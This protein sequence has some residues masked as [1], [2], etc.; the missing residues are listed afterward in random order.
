MYPA[1]PPPSAAAVELHT[2][3]RAFMQQ[4]VFPR[5]L[6]FRRHRELHGPHDHSVPPAIEELKGIAEAQGLWNLFLPHVSGLTQLEYAT[7]AELTGWSM[8]LAPEA[9]NCSAPDTG[10]MEL[11]HLLGTEEQ[12]QRWLEPLL[13]GS[14]GRRSR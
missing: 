14:S 3:L 13:A 7:L 9:L 11:L 10:N 12:R 2:K 4:E 5:E 8:E 6:D 1:Y